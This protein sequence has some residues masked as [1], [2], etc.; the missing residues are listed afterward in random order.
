MMVYSDC[1]TFIR[2]IAFGVYK[3]SDTL[4]NGAQLQ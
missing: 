4:P 2:F 1:V 3:R